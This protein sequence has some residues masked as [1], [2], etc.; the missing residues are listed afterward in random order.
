MRYIPVGGDERSER[1]VIPIKVLNG[2]KRSD[3][4]CRPKIY[5]RRYQQA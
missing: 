2:R 3:S 4:K 1:F 5:R